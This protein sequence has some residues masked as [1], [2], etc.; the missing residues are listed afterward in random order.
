[1][2]S[3]NKKRRNIPLY[4]NFVVL[5]KNVQNRNRLNFQKFNKKKWYSLITFI[6]REQSRRKSIFRV[7]D[8]FRH[9]L[10]KFSNTFQRKFKQN[11]QAKKR[12]KLFYGNILDK[13]VK[14]YVKVSF[15]RRRQFLKNNQSSSLN[16]L[17][18]FE[19]RL[20]TILYRAHFVSSFYQARQLITH[21]NV[22]VN[23]VPVIDA[24][25]Q[26]SEGDIIEISHK[27]WP[28]IEYNISKSYFWPLSPNYLVINYKTIQ[29]V[30]IGGINLT[31]FSIYYPYKLELQTILHTYK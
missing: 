23:G 8:I 29:I 28:L 2:A 4:K 10:P 27:S 3:K 26:L 20:D 14:K 30:Y 11:V 24:S 7:F 15:Q 19:Q 1:M 5:K 25:F 13:V 17:Q 22:L 21:K 12:F 18:T 31:N 9:Q 16:F 6:R